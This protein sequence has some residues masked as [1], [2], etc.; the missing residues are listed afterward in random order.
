LFVARGR[1]RV[2]KLG[3]F[4]AAVETDDKNILIE[5]KRWF[6]ALWETHSRPITPGLLKQAEEEWNRRKPTP[7]PGE[8]VLEKYLLEPEWFRRRVTVIPAARAS[9]I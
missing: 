5:A 9:S 6:D 8:T 4:E 1:G 2:G 7:R 3:T